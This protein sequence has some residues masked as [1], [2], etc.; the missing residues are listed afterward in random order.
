[1]GDAASRRRNHKDVQEKGK[2]MIQIVFD[3]DGDVDGFS[4]GI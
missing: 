4:V 1:M 3:G 2:T